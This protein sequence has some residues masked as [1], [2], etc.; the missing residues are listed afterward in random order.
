M[1]PGNEAATRDRVPAAA[2]ISLAEEIAANASATLAPAQ[3]NHALQA[4][5]DRAVALLKQKADLAAEIAD[6]RREVRG[7]GLVPS[8]LLKLA[9]EHLRDAEQRR[10]AAEAAEVEELYRQ[11]LGLP[12]FDFAR[13]TAE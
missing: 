10:K 11:G 5:F 2:V 4:H 6:W 9:R 3:V 13:R 8:A 12:L 7:D 1:P